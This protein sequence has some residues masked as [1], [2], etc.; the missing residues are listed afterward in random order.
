MHTLVHTHMYS[1]RVNTYAHTNPHTVVNVGFR[2][3]EYSAEEGDG[4]VKVCADLSGRAD[5]E[6]AVLFSTMMAQDGAVGM[7]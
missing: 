5:R 1:T 6:V 2:E 3:L 7:S 4:L